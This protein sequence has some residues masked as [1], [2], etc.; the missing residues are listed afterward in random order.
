MVGNLDLIFEEDYE[1]IERE[2]HPSP[3]KASVT[4]EAD[5]L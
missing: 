5:D 4:L 3:T 1:E 2:V